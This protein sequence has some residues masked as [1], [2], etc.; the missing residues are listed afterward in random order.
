MYTENLPLLMTARSENGL[1]Q[2]GISRAALDNMTPVNPPKLNKNINPMLNNI[3]VLRPT[4]LITID[5]LGRCPQLPKNGGV[6][7]HKSQ[8]GRSGWVGPHNESESVFT[9]FSWL[10]QNTSRGGVKCPGPV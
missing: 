9:A 6:G 2:N 7:A 3:G 4:S 5:R 8:I 10:R 1:V